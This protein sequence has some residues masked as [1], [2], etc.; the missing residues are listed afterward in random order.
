MIMRHRRLG[1]ASL[2]VL[3]VAAGASVPLE[4]GEQLYAALKRTE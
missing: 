1:A 3:A 2:S 4:Q